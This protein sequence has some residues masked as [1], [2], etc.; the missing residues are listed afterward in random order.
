MQYPNDK[1]LFIYVCAVVG[2]AMGSG[3]FEI[4]DIEPLT[5]RAVTTYMTHLAE[6]AQK[7]S[8]APS[9][10]VQRPPGAP[11]T[12]AP[13][14]PDP[15]RGQ[16]GVVSGEAGGK[17]FAVWKDDRIGLGKKESPV[18]GK[19]WGEVTWAEAYRLCAAGNAQASKYLSWISETY[20]PGTD[21]KW[22]AKNNAMKLRA[23]CVLQMAKKGQVP[24]EPE[25]DPF[26]S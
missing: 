14:A 15:F 7:S 5:G 23:A 26:P 18:N 11:P 4:A 8:P 19:T 13:P 16:G 3:K 21:P 25:Y 9:Q 1:D 17:P 20:D 12:Y 2:R 10:S 24:A 22:A 6:Y